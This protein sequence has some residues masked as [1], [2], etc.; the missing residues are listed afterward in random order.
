MIHHEL[1]TKLQTHT[2]THSKKSLTVSLDGFQ[3]AWFLVPNIQHSCPAR[4]KRQNA[5]WPFRFLCVL[6]CMYH[7]GHTIIMMC[8]WLQWDGLHFVCLHWAINL[9]ATQQNTHKRSDHFHFEKTFKD[10]HILRAIISFYFL[11]CEHFSIFLP[12]EKQPVTIL[13]EPFLRHF[14]ATKF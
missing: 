7:T 8:L 3:I 6:L 5:S 13:L 10:F 11:S 1:L 2:H 12:A 9:K 4:Q 14:H